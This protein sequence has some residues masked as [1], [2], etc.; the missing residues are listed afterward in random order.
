M[1]CTICRADHK[2]CLTHL[3]EVAADLRAYSKWHS[4]PKQD[5]RAVETAIRELELQL[6]CSRYLEAR[7]PGNVVR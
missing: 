5:L 3:R 2:D 4:S 7:W 6:L 1:T